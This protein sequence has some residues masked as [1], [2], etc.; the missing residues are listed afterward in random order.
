MK[1]FQLIILVTLLGCSVNPNP[2]K[3]TEGKNDECFEYP[4][5]IDS[6]RIRDL[7]DSAR[8]YVYTWQC[9]DE[10]N[11]KSGSD[12]TIMFGQMSLN[13]RKLVVKRD[14]L[15]LNF[16]FMDKLQPVLSSMTKDNKEM[17]TG[18]AFNIKTKRKIYMFSP[19]GFSITTKGGDNRF[20]NPLQPE[21]ISY[22][23]NNWNKLD[24]CFRMLAEQKGVVK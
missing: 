11:P 20:E 16:E 18:V 7:Y 24:N 21:V 9:D 3:N 14:T 17:I 12:K 22:I 13:F 6:L 5:S 2:K 19:N 4:I 15:E 8:W 1:K 10:Y 23:K